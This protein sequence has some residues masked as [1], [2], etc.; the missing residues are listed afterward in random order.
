MWI[1]L[2]NSADIPP[3]AIRCCFASAS[4][5]GLAAAGVGLEMQSFSAFGG[6]HPVSLPFLHSSPTSCSTTLCLASL[7]QT[8]QETQAA[9]KITPAASSS[10]NTTAK[11]DG[12]PFSPRRAAVSDLKNSAHLDA[13]ALDSINIVTTPAAYRF[14]ETLQVQDLNIILRHFGD[15]KR[16]KD[17][18]QLFDWMQKHGKTN[19]ASYSSFIKSMGQAQNPVKALQIYNSIQDELMRYDVAVCNSVI[20]C[21]VRNGKFDSSIQLFEKMKRDGLTPD[22]VTYSTLLSG[23]TKAKDGYSK[24]M[25]LVKELESN[26]LQMDAVIYGTLLAICAS[27]NLCQE[28]EA[29]FQKMKNEGHSPNIF[30]YGSLL[31]AYSL[32][33]NFSKADELLEDLKAVGFVPNKVILTTLLKVYVRGGLF[34]KARELL[35]ELEAMGYAKDEI[36]YCILMDGLAKAGHIDEAKEIFEYVK[37][38]DVQ[39]DGYSHSII[40][41]AFCRSGLLEEAKQLA[42]N[43]EASYE[44]IAERVK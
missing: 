29:F 26:G 37:N 32:D 25:Q 44:L 39:S 31:N 42:Q 34:E 38:K 16:W 35:R 33:G 13:A 18:S 27:S 41:S 2:A 43:Y 19:V 21:L 28:A 9:A 15:M 6:F 7:Y 30:H 5:A 14:E 1:Y 8:L 24:A 23:C 11:R 22:A 12:L 17:V 3:S 40:I 10:R 4:M 36:P 20:G